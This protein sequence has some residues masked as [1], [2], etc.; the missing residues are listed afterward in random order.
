[1]VNLQFL[2]NILRV[3]NKGG[4]DWWEHAARTKEVRNVH[5][6]LVRKPEWRGWMH[7]NNKDPKEIGIECGLK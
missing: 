6:I 2:P 1:L 7:N 3:Q 5:K 4:D